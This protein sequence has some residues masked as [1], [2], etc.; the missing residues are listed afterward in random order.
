METHLAIHPDDDYAGLKSP[1]YIYEFFG[2]R[3]SND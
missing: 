1:T 2:E 3:A